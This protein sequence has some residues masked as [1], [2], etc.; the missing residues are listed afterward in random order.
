MKIEINIR[1]SGISVKEILYKEL[2][3][4]HAQVTKL[5]KDESGILLSSKRVFVTERVKEGD[6]LEL[7]LEDREENLNEGIAPVEL[8]ID[9]IYEDEYIVCVN[10]ASGMPTHPSHS[11]HDDTLANALCFYY[12]NKGRP[13]VFRAVNRLDADT[14]GIVLIAKDRT[15]AFKLGKALQRGEFKKEYYAVLEGV[16]EQK[17]GS[18]ETYIRRKEDSIIFRINACEGIESEY[19]KTLYDTIFVRD[20]H[21]LVRARPL[22]GRT[23]QLRVHFLH[24]GHPI[25]GDSLYAKAD[26]RLMLHAYSLEFVHPVTAETMTVEARMPKDFEYYM[27]G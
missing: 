1:Q 17:K 14:S 25:M 22:T 21:A 8:P 7:A 19:A 11:H 9:I 20:G 12:Q 15:T 10:K 18:I 6:I 2:G 16:P 3:L 26:K 13:F 24:I 27:K 4:S 5:K 23:H